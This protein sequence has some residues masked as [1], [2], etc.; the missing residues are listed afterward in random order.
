MVNDSILADADI[1]TAFIYI[2]STWPRD[3]CDRYDVIQ[4]QK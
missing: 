3:I 1:I 4:T 2:K